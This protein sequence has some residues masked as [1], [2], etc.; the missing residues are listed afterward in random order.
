MTELEQVL[1]S[2]QFVGRTEMLR[3]LKGERNCASAAIKAKCF[4]CCGYYEDGKVDCGVK[5]CPL[6]PWM[7]YRK[8]KAPK[9]ELTESQKRA[10]ETL[11]KSK[12]IKHTGEESLIH[13]ASQNSSQKNESDK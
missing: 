9:K 13:D 8:E 10:L 12:R 1:Q 2:R 7:P 4:D 3:H 11:K 6:Y 5:G